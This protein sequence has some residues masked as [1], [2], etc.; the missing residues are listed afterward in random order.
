MARWRYMTRSERRATILLALVA[1]FAFVIIGYLVV[2][3]LV[4]MASLAGL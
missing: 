4:S 1:P 3:L 2:V